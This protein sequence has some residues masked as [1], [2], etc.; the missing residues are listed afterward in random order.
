M[1]LCSFWQLCKRKFYESS[2]LLKCIYFSDKRNLSLQ[3][4]MH[5]PSSRTRDSQHLGT[6]NVFWRGSAKLK[7]RCTISKN[8]LI[9]PFLMTVLLMV[10]DLKNGIVPPVSQRCTLPH[11]HKLHQHGA[12]WHYGI[13]VRQNLDQDLPNRWMGKR[14]SIAW[15]PWS[16]HSNPCYLFLYSSFK[17]QVLLELSQNI[18]DLRAARHDVANIR[19]TTLDIVLQIISNRPLFVVCQNK[20][21][22]QH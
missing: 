4:V 3:G 13:P 21:H 16:L 22:L 10:A 7:E 14:G 1:K 17:A 19:G 11:Q 9:C 18:F 12:A 2:I 8:E 20:G 5:M 6:D 15:L